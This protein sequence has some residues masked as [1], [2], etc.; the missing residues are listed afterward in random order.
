MPTT[1]DMLKEKR[2][3]IHVIAERYGVSNIRVF[4]SVV[5]G[6]DDAKSDIDLLVNMPPDRD[7]FEVG[8]FQFEASQLLGRYVDVVIDGSIHPALKTQITSEAAV[9]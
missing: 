2:D 3:A 1:L 8:G 9:L 4:G 6:E 7:M 5:R